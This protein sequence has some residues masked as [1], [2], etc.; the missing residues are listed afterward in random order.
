VGL[1]QPDNTLDHP[2]GPEN[3]KVVEFFAPGT[4][5]PGGSKTAFPIY[6]GN[7]QPLM[8]DGRVVLRYGD[9]AKGNKQWRRTVADAAKIA[10][11]HQSPVDFPLILEILFHLERPRSHYRTGKNSHLLRDG[12]P[13]Y[14]AVRPDVTKLTRSTEDAMLD[15]IYR[16]DA[17]IIEQ[18]CRKVYC[19][20]GQAG[21]AIRLT[22]AP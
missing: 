19:N 18:R 15:I 9:D 3:R 8:K 5:R 14:P 4:P 13:S 10:F 7:G 16:D 22:K 11:V 12:A 2:F 1:F 17:L 20:P 21:A 6:L